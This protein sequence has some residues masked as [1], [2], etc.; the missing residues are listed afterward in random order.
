MTRI[1]LST[2]LLDIIHQFCAFCDELFVQR[3]VSGMTLDLPEH[4]FLKKQEIH[5]NCIKQVGPSLWVMG[6]EFPFVALYVIQ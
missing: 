5:E 2:L 3:I 1:F 4:G 6:S